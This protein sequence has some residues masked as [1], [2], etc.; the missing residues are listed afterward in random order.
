M[1]QT[2]PTPADE[3]A[4]DVLSKDLIVISGSARTKEDAIR[5]AGAL[6]VQAEAVSPAYVDAMLERE[7]SYTTYMG[8]LLAIPH[9]TNE[10]KASIKRSAISLVRYDEPL[11]WGDGNPVRVVV[12]IAGAE[13]GHLEVLSKVALV[14]S[15]DDL[16]RGILQA[17][18]AGEI[19]DIL[20][21]VNDD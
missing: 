16:A 21:S 18:S 12:G 13:G 9:G 10:S 14:F 8:S 7:R 11:E 19:Y 3:G 4:D 17:G 5:E 15:D 20:Q 1:T 6:L 2:S